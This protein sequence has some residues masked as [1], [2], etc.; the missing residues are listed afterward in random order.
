M[1]LQARE[2]R[3]RAGA[4]SL[5]LGRLRNGLPGV[6]AKVVDNSNF[7]VKTEKVKGLDI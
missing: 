6:P 5:A 1:G 2:G 3:A 7:P 4:L